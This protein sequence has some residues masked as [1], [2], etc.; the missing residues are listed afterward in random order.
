[1]QSVQKLTSILQ[2]CLELPNINKPFIFVKN[3]ESGNYW[4]DYNLCNPYSKCSCL[5]LYMYSMEFGQPP[6]YDVLNR[7]MRQ[8]DKTQA[9]N[10]GP[11]AY[12]LGW[13]TAIADKNKL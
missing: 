10:L 13:I 1:M 11:F 9:K 6:L 2:E 8:K 5:I 12:A 4:K 3:T 7:A